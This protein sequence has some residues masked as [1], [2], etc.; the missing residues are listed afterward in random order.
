[1]IVVEGLETDEARAV[2][3]GNAERTGAK[4][5]GPVGAGSDTPVVADLLNRSL[6]IY[7]G[8]E[9]A[10]QAQERGVRLREGKGQVGVVDDLE[11]LELSGLAVGECVKA[12]DLGIGVSLG[13]DRDQALKG[14][15]DVVGREGGAVV[16]LDAL[17][18]LDL[19][20][21]AVVRDG[22]EVL[23]DDGLDLV[24]VGVELV[25]GLGHVLGDADGGRGGLGVKRGVGLGNAKADDLCTVSACRVIGATAANEGDARGGNGGAQDSLE[26][27][28]TGDVGSQCMGKCCLAVGHGWFLS[29]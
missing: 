28:A 19:V 18:E 21:E 26:E 16:E 3:L 24:G 7:V 9:L 22:G 27:A 20:G 25:E 14:E 17:V 12:D 1:M 6:R 29:P 4:V 13:V 5:G 2:V 10:E 11:A 8:V 15:L 23:G